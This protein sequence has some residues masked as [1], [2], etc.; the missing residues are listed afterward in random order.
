MTASRNEYIS[1][2]E[3]IAEIEPVEYILI[4]GHEDMEIIASSKS[5]HD[6]L[7][8]PDN[9]PTV[10]EFF[11]VEINNS[12]HKLLID[13]SGL[14]SFHASDY[15]GTFRN[16]DRIQAFSFMPGF[17]S[18]IFTSDIKENR[19]VETGTGTAYRYSKDL[20]FSYKL[21][22]KKLTFL[23]SSVS[24]ILGYTVDEII[25]SDFDQL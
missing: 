24:D 16:F 17:V 4:E 14:E 22:D 11:P 12:L 23:S 6:L 20:F 25:Q 15:S 13:G 1:V 8:T 3:A 5:F 9:K 10:S 7:N 21:S 18:L 2:L 19:N